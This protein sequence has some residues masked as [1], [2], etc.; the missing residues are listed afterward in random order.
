MKQTELHLCTTGWAI[1]ARMEQEVNPSKQSAIYYELLDHR[2]ECNE[3]TDP[4]VEHYRLYLRGQKV[5]V[6]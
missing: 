6:E 3:C 1:H 2:A 5:K 4:R